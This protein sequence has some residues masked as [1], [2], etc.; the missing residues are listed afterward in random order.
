MKYSVAFLTLAA[1]LV[2]AQ[3]PAAGDSAKDAIANNPP[4]QGGIEKLEV[5]S[6]AQGNPTPAG[7]GPGFSISAT[8][9]VKLDLPGIFNDSD[10]DSDDEDDRKKSG[11]GG[12]GS[13]MGYVVAGVVGAGA[14]IIL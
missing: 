1:A 3:G 2:S 7:S 8:A 14:A 4:T 13:M 5:T 10:S 12:P 9:G 11:A 6:V